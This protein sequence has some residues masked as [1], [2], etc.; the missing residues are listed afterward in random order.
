MGRMPLV[1]LK[2]LDTKQAKA[3][4]A[5]DK[6][7][8]PDECRTWIQSGFNLGL[9]CG[10]IVVLEHAEALALPDTWTAVAGDGTRQVYL[11][12]PGARVDTS[13]GKL[14][15][16]VFVR[17]LGSVCPVP[18]SLDASGC[19][20]VWAEGKAPGEVEL[21]LM[22]EALI[23]SL[24]IV[25]QLASSTVDLPGAQVHKVVC[26]ED[27]LQHVG[28][29]DSAILYAQAYLLSYKALQVTRGAY[30]D[31]KRSLLAWN[32]RRGKFGY[33][34]LP[35]DLLAQYRRAV[36]EFKDCY[37]ALAHDERPIVWLTADISRSCEQL[38]ER[39]AQ[40]HPPG[41]ERAL[42]VHAGR[43]AQ[44][45]QAEDGSTSVREVGLPRLRE[46]ASAAARFRVE[47]S[48]GTNQKPPKDLLQAFLARGGWSFCRLDGVH[49]VPFVRPD[50]TVVVEPGYDAATRAVALLSRDWAA[51][52][53]LTRRTAK[54]A[55]RTLL[56]PVCDFPFVKKPGPSVALALVL[57]LL[58]R[59]AIKGPVPL[60]AVRS[61]TP[62][63][64]K[65]L[66]VKTLGL[67]GMGYD[68]AMGLPMVASNTTA[69]QVRLLSAARSA[70]QLV[71]Y[72]NEGGAFGSAVMS[73]VLTSGTV[74]MP[75]L[76]RAHEGE[77]RRWPWSSVM[78]VTGN[79]ISFAEDTA[80]RSLLMDIDCGVSAPESRAGFRFPRLL[81]HV[82]E[83][84]GDYVTAGLT[85]LAAHARAKRPIAEGVPAYGG[86]EEWDEVV[87]HALLWAGLPDPLD[88]RPGDDDDETHRRW[89]PVLVEWR[90]VFGD[91]DLELSEVLRRLTRG[92]LYRMVRDACHPNK[93][94]ASTLGVQLA[95]IEG[96]VFGRYRVVRTRGRSGTGSHDRVKSRWLVEEFT[97]EQMD[98]ARV[99]YLQAASVTREEA[100]REYE[101][102]QARERE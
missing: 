89:H 73:S 64:G 69:L 8:T 96:R 81:E 72:D 85:I 31:V 55:A 15:A 13:R 28:P 7:E 50:G 43:L 59:R 82:R 53:T 77:T 97:D 19:M 60:F 88:A 32:R 3:T 74:A 26:S 61:H 79:N 20:T 99:S 22:P 25:P 29:V 21:A 2:P 30:E 58:A 49:A 12:V 91:E 39:L 16:G 9:R 71:V 87:R 4:W 1:P 34:G 33:R 45:L 66:L 94:A 38:E 56:E 18:S 10:N 65:T 41:H 102:R 40:A 24:A 42:Y 90:R 84:L 70:E 5:E 98:T 23:E 67:I 76:K 27:P 14:A 46:V 48:Q 78:V 11:R 6:P 62:G 57:T 52:A 80:R 68:P 93:V 37:P 17:G 92:S 100:I 44:A 86:F 47:G 75:G 83:H 35:K 63:T 54:A 51:P 95:S 36:R 101:E